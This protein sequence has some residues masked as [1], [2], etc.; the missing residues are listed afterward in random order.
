M[1]R[2]QIMTVKSNRL[3]ELLR[4]SIESP[5]DFDELRTLLESAF[6]ATTKNQLGLRKSNNFTSRVLGFK[7]HDHYIHSCVKRTQAPNYDKN[8]H[9]TRRISSRIQE[10]LIHGSPMNFHEEFDRLD[11]YFFA[12]GEEFYLR[13]A[14]DDS[15]GELNHMPTPEEAE[16]LLPLL[17]FLNT[18]KAFKEL[19]INFEDK[20]WEGQPEHYTR[21]S[22][23]DIIMLAK[24]RFGWPMKTPTE[25]CFLDQFALYRHNTQ[26]HE[27]TITL[28]FDNA[29][30][31][32]V[33]LKLE[34]Q[35]DRLDA[36]S[37][38]SGFVYNEQDYV[39]T[40]LR[41]DTLE[42]QPDFIELTRKKT[43]TVK[44]N[45]KHLAK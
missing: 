39:R 40:Q 31:K 15:V 29:S 44:L 1:S 30:V 4:T 14:F 42:S 19:Q 3:A 34:E 26:T 27:S 16:A 22:L 37:I 25:L 43:L 13:R 41:L 5:A 12:V 18:P 17:G 6:E 45:P 9:E 7:N 33:L 10:A 36:W 23:F 38:Y 32:S 21:A 24:D 11:R 2:E 28:N 8:V 35:L 20:H